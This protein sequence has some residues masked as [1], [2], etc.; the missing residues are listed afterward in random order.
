M[1]AV[2]MD[3]LE[4][5]LSGTLEPVDERH[6]E[7]HLSTC[8]TCREEIASLQDVSH[9]FGAFRPEEGLDPAPGFTAGVMQH[10]AGLKPAPTFASLF[11]LDFAFGR[12]LVFAS[13]MVLAILGGFLATHEAQ[14]PMG[15]SPEAI[16]AQ[17]ESP[18]FD[19]AAAQD[20]MLVTLTAYEQH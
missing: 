11:T 10:I 17:Q 3:S 14:S 12:R 13:L 4:D 8:G 19:S 9:L 15:P 6:V 7:A 18:A 16:M 2:V 1:H 5:Y 20:N